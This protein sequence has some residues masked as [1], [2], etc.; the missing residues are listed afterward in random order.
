MSLERGAL[1][2][3]ASQIGA[4]CSTLASASRRIE[5]TQM[6]AFTLD[7][8]DSQPGFRGDLPKPNVAADDLLVRVQASS[9]NPADAAIA[10]GMLK[11]MAEYE[12]PVTLGRDFAGVVEEVGSGVTEHAAGDPVFGFVLHANPAVH[13]GSWADYLVITHDSVAHSPEGVDIKA[14]GAAPVAGLTAI[15]AFDALQPSAGNNVLVIGASGGVGSFFVQLARS[16]GA[17]VVA[18]ALPEDSDYLRE[19]G[20]SDTLDR[21]S[22]LAAQVRERF[23]DGV[24]A[25]LDLV[26]FTPDASVLKEGGRLASPLGAA[27]EGPRTCE[28]D[29]IGNDGESRAPCS[30]ARRP[31]LARP[32]PRDV[33]ARAGRRSAGST[34]EHPY[35]GKADYRA[36]LIGCRACRVGCPAR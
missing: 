19:L 7:S 29:G 3:P 28:P 6:R 17:Y 14:V 32:R 25:L 13:D 24:D 20:V 4:P 16:A 8:F 10:S 31:L 30:A 22:D 12:F 33:W 23:P 15:A 5:G 11:S 27:G 2:G 35:A 18:P 36:R 1:S 34:R 21:D 26:S 9:V